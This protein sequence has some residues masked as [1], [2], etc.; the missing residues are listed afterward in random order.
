M[1]S[2]LCD[3]YMRGN[4]IS[5]AWVYIV[6]NVIKT[7]I[8]EDTCK[9]ARCRDTG[10]LDHVKAAKSCAHNGSGHDAMQ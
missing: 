10:E 3:V 7:Q 2:W 9:T 5:S 6:H 1:R 8:K 4:I